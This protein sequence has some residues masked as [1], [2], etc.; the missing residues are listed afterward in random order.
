MKRIISA[1]LL[2]GVIAV[3]TVGCSDKTTATKK[4]SVSTPNGST[5]QS[6]TTETKQSGNNPPPPAK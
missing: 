6:T 4:T 3:G 2:M 1:V 5:E